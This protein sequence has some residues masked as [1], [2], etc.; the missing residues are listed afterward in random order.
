MLLSMVALGSPVKQ[1]LNTWWW[2]P[3]T[4]KQAESVGIVSRDLVYM[5]GMME[6]NETAVNQMLAEL[7]DVADIAAAANITLANGLVSC[8]VNCPAG[9]AQHWHGAF[10]T[11][12]AR[13]APQSAGVALTVAEMGGEYTWAKTSTTC[14]GSKRGPAR[15]VK[16]GGGTG[17]IADGRVHLSVGAADAAAATQQL[18]E[19]I[20]LAGG[21]GLQD[22]FECTAFV[23]DVADAAAVGSALGAA[24]I[25]HAVVGAGG[26][27]AVSLW[28]TATTSAEPKTVTSVGGVMSVASPR[29]IHVSA[30]PAAVNGSANALLTVGLALERGGSS[31][32]LAVNCVYFTSAFDAMDDVFGGFYNV[33]NAQHPPPPSRTEF[34]ATLPC[35]NQGCEALVKCTA[36]MP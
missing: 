23:R 24:Q 30:V 3:G 12:L 2:P 15:V 5:T 28:C 4:E 33:F 10:D 34:V 27:D 31:L 6:T 26:T 11:A 8:L 19:L 20:T 35:A 18:G 7:T 22:A 25:A 9:S 1:V 17:A 29:L 16:Q 13:A 14:I 36:A 32:D 21:R